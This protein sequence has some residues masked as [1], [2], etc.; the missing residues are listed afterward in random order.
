MLILKSCIAMLI[1]ASIIFSQDMAITGTLR[2]SSTSFP[3]QG[4]EVRLLAKGVADTTSAE[5]KFGLLWKDIPISLLRGTAVFTFKPP[6]VGNRGDVVFTLGESSEL[7]VA[8]YTT[9]GR[10]VHLQREV[11]QAGVHSISLH[12]HAS[13]LF[14][15][16]ISIGDKAYTFKAVSTRSVAS[17]NGTKRQAADNSDNDSK[18]ALAK[19]MVDATV[20][21]TL[22]ISL[23]GYVTKKFAVGSV[24]EDTV[25]MLRQ[26]PK[27]F[28]YSGTWE[29]YS[30]EAAEDMDFL[31]DTVHRVNNFGYS[32]GIPGLS[33]YTAGSISSPS[34]LVTIS[35]GRFS[36]ITSANSLSGQFS[37]DTL[38][39]GT[40]KVG[41]NPERL[42]LARRLTQDSTC[43]RVFIIIRQTPTSRKWTFNPGDTLRDTV[44][45]TADSIKF[46]IGAFS[47]PA[48]IFVADSACKTDLVSKSFPL[49]TGNNIFPVRVVSATGLHTTRCHIAVTRK[50]SSD[51][52]LK[53]IVVDGF[54]SWDITPGINADS[55]D[56][57]L[58]PKLNDTITAIG[59]TVESSHS[60]STIK[61]NGVVTKSGVKSGPI[62]LQKGENKIDIQIIA[63]DGTTSKI[64]HL[65][66]NKLANTNAYLDSIQL[67]VGYLN[68]AFTGNQNN[69]C[70]IVPENTNSISVKPFPHN[71][72][73]K[74][75]VN[76][77]IVPAGT[78]SSPIP[79]LFEN[80][81]F[82]VK[83][84]A[85]D[86]T[87]ILLYNFSVMNIRWQNV[88]PGSMAPEAVHN[89]QLFFGST[90]SILH[91]LNSK[92]G[93]VIWEFKAKYSHVNYPTLNDNYV[94]FMNIPQGIGNE[95]IGDSCK[96]YCI[97]RKTGVKQ[98]EFDVI[99]GF[100]GFPVHPVVDENYIYFG[101]GEMSQ[102][103]MLYCLNA[104]TG[105]LVWYKDEYYDG[106]FVNLA[107][108]DTL[109]FLKRDLGYLECRRTNSGSIIWESTSGKV[110]EGQILCTKDLIITTCNFVNNWMLGLSPLTGD[111]IF[112]NNAYGSGPASINGTQLIFETNNLSITSLNISDG[113]TLW[114][115]PGQSY[116]GSSP[117]VCGNYVYVND[118]YFE[119]S[120]LSKNVTC[121][122]ALNGKVRWEFNLGKDIN[123]VYAPIIGDG[124]LFIS[125]SGGGII[126][127]DPMQIPA[128]S[129]WKM[130][131]ANGMRT[132]NAAY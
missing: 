17:R 57:R 75:L 47:K 94:Y 10:L 26:T 15:H 102:R 104:A 32:Y 6:V 109:L 54:S 58:A 128:R 131:R 111:S 18:G 11:R 20:R 116:R 22:Q 43:A 106:E 19:S 126:C 127:V 40:Y 98:W 29:G 76:E 125:T 51:C 84:T 12:S 114:S 65:L 30:L 62:A 88:F 9:Q 42:Y 53:S 129:A 123:N 44:E 96:L 83:V 90:D 74:I 60:F 46:K 16:R 117:A 5:G 132:G 66:V 25:I 118:N 3:L 80:N 63:L 41:S 85:E 14:I 92:T 99:F 55:L 56:Y 71:N 69:Y 35:G 1:A 27:P 95:I 4:A 91:C 52:N 82:S 68:K 48:K 79:L 97:D 112:G 124:L 72:K 67:S 103:N 86:D 49:T 77:T 34:G 113:V 21:D 110:C 23:N 13:G 120:S 93:A 115:T 28:D 31:V 108:V 24:I 119:N 130:Y 121:I 33:S 36:R 50:T 39:S 59:I 101:T 81:N 2:D 73:A 61:I 89:G 100:G 38:C 8:T 70:I 107:L 64:Y 7:K 45:S 37:G 87:T 122:S 105:A 78:S